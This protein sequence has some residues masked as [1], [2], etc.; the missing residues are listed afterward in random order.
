MEDIPVH[1]LGRNAIKKGAPIGQG[2]MSTVFKGKLGT[3][4]VALKQA[5]GSVHTLLHEAQTIAKLD[6]R[7]VVKVFGIWE[8]AEQQLFMVSI[9]S[10]RCWR[11]KPG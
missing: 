7:N 4:A 5:Q 8:N 3:M 10:R 11:R 1:M 9:A 6:H 2:G